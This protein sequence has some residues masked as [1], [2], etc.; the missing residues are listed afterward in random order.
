M[1]LQGSQLQDT[2]F[3]VPILYLWFIQTGS[4]STITL[5]GT[6]G[7][8]GTRSAAWG[9]REAGSGSGGCRDRA[10]MQVYRVK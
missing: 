3:I 5:S 2:P 9:T 10:L 8:G 7:T 6:T 1:L 4:T